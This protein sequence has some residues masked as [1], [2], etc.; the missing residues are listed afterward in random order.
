MHELSIARAVVATVERHA[1]G[2]PVEVVKLRVGKLRQVAPDS[3]DFSFGFVT[4]GT[5]CEGA[6]LE[7]EV[8]PARLRCNACGEKWV[9]EEPLF[10]CSGCGSPD[11]EV[12]AGEELEVESIVIEEEEAA[13]CIERQ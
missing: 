2:R 12:V 11:V 3:L 6:R 5:V 9:L 7:L 10:R 4:R 1:A 13:A 8:V